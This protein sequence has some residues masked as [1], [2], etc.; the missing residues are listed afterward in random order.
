MSRDPQ[1][2]M[3]SIF[4][5]VSSVCRASKFLILF[6]FEPTGPAHARYSHQTKVYVELAMFCEIL[7]V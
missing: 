7:S 2:N 3:H 5:A 6:H 1:D 4:V